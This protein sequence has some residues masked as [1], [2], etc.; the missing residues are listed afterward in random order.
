MG[1]LE[2]FPQLDIIVSP[3]IFEVVWDMET[4]L[5]YFYPFMEAL[6]VSCKDSCIVQKYDNLNRLFEDGKTV[7]VR[8]VNLD[9]LTRLSNYIISTML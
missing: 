3:W 7:I 9:I 5:L 4:F 6:L 8:A 2:K 1:V